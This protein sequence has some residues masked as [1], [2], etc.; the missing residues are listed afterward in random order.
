M[1]W[2]VTVSQA[3]EDAN[4]GEKIRTQEADGVL[5]WL[6]H[7]Y[8]M[9]CV[10]GLEPPHAVNE[11]TMKRRDSLTIRDQWLAE[12]TAQDDGGEE[13]TDDLW[14]AY[15]NWCAHGGVPDQD[16]GSKIGFGRWL[17]EHPG[18]PAKVVRVEI[19]GRDGKAH[20]K[21]LRGW[22]GR[23]LLGELEDESAGRGGFADH[24][25]AVAA[26]VTDGG[27]DV[28]ASVPPVCAGH[29]PCGGSCD[30]VTDDF[31]EASPLREP[32]GSSIRTSSQKYLSIRHTRHVCPGQVRDRCAGSSVTYPYHLSHGAARDPSLRR[33][34]RL[35][36]PV[37]HPRL[38]H[39]GKRRPP[40][41]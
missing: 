39:N 29:G 28:H 9:C 25:A 37:S 32:G 35:C 17:S 13:T 38:R 19:R 31:G 22:R 10:L 30:G 5:D 26:L 11:A 16:R 12:M 4:L 20:P 27:T 15:R 33:C 2:S 7:D 21:Q 1:P 41:Y 34:A 14:V 23:R 8:D 6:L 36:S 18:L 40:W 24:G 3:D